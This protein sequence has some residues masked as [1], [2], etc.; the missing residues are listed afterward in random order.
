MTHSP[1]LRHGPRRPQRHRPRPLVDFYVAR[2][3]LGGEG[4][5]GRLRVPRRRRP[6]GAHALAAERRR[7]R[8]RDP[9]PAPPLLRGRLGRGGLGRRGARARRGLRLYHDGIVPHSEGASSGGIFFEDPDGIRLEIFTGAGVV[10][11]RP[12][13][14]RPDLRLLLGRWPSIPG[15]LAVQERAGVADRAAGSL[16]MF[17]ARGAA[18]GRRVPRGA[19]LD[20]ARRRRRATTAC[21]RR[22]LYGR[23]GLHHHADCRRR[24]TSRR[25]PLAGDPLTARSNGPVGGLA[26][27]PGTRRRMRLNGQAPTAADGVDDRARAGL[28]EL[29]EVH[30]DAALS[31]VAPTRPTRVAGT[32]LDARAHRAARAPP[33]PPSSPPAPRA[34]ASTPP[35]AAAT[36]ASCASSTSTRST[37]PTT[38]ATR[39]STRSATS[40]STRRPASRS[41]TRRPA[42]RCYLSGRA[43]ILWEDGGFPERAAPRPA[44]SGRCG[45]PRSRRAAAL[46]ARTSS[47][48]PRNPILGPPPRRKCG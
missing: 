7:V 10:A 17:D 2:L 1:P 21:G 27:E 36:R 6:A 32:S 12:V 30:R 24:S 46:G 47:A 45:P 8:D 16:G 31:R 33:T 15:E 9:G 4:P 11:D 22:V 35:T 14:R 38:R 41:S 40:R 28:L 42:R 3:R 26:L 48:E 19:A 39:C 37:G 43:E 5:R 44:H 25:G 23:P 29:P 34:T 20:R 18:G 13:R